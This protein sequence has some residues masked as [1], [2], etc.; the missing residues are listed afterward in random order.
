MEETVTRNSSIVELANTISQNASKIDEYLRSQ[1]LPTPSFAI[2]APPIM[3]LPPLLMRSRDEILEACSE[4]QALT[5][6]PVA[7]LTRLTSPTV[8]PRQ[9]SHPSILPNYQLSDQY[10]HESPSHLPI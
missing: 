10:P 2:D 8:S 4:L 1:G 9:R 5:E 6:G 3:T 7:H